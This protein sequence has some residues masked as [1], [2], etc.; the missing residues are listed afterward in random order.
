MIMKSHTLKIVRTG[1]VA[2]C[3]AVSAALTLS[4]GSIAATS[5]TL[6]AA[7]SA[8]VDKLSGF[9]NGFKTMEGEFVQIGPRGGISKGTFYISK[10]GKV[11][12][13]YQ[14]PNPF[15]IVSDGTWVE[16]RNRKNK[17]ADHYPLSAT[18]LSLILANE[19]DLRKH[20]RILKVAHDGNSI[21][22]TLE[23]KN[24]AVPGKLTLI[25][26]ESKN[27]LKEWIVIDGENRRTTISLVNMTPD[28]AIN[29]KLFKVQKGG[30]KF[31]DDSK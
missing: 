17:R 29:P 8:G 3:I 28:V 21:I 15:L 26:D 22:I 30:K 1:F 6:T 31:N 14:K 4:A 18:P 13:D 11:R 19:V 2:G 5:D 12:F 9:L 20:A 27:V 16:I 7:D 10:P 24:R 25:Y 23:D